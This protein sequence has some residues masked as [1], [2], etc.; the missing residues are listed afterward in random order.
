[1]TGDR[2]WTGAAI[3]D[4][5]DDLGARSAICRPPAPIERPL[6]IETAI[7]YPRRKDVWPPEMWAEMEAIRTGPVEEDM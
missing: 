6:S 1:M 7:N 4:L 5:A 2:K 3:F